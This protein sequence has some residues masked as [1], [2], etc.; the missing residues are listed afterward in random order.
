[1]TA[2]IVPIR[3]DQD[4]LKPGPLSFMPEPKLAIKADANNGRHKITAPGPFVPPIGMLV[5]VAGFRYRVQKH[6]ADKGEITLRAIGIAGKLKRFP[7]HQAI[8]MAF[9]EFWQRQFGKQ[10]ETE[11][12]QAAQQQQ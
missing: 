1:M 8:L 9:Q 2:K 5:D 3:K 12:K 10:K 11:Q 4:D 6:H 7:L